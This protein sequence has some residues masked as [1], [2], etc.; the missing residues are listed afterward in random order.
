MIAYKIATDEDIEL[1]MSSRLE[2]LRVV[3]H[4][5]EAYRFP[6]ELVSY[7]RSYF[8]EGE[9]TT[10]LAMDRDRVIGCASISYIRIMPTFSHPTGNRAHLMNV[11]TA[12]DYRG[13]GIAQNMVTMLIEDA[14]KQGATEISLDATE[15]GR[16]LY[17]KLG[18]TDSDECMVLVRHTSDQA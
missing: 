17:R 16:P 5:D 11:Y 6:G 2:M 7:S 3:N 14:W 15:L 18:F 4:L 8:L 12:A 13:Q 10:V 9:Q 1:C